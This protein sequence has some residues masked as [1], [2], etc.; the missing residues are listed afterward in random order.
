[1]CGLKL[2]GE[3]LYDNATVAFIDFVISIWWLF[4][5]TMLLKKERRGL[6][7]F[8]A[9]FGANV[10]SSLKSSNTVMEISLSIAITAAI[11]WFYNRNSVRDY[12]S[13]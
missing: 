4:A 2:F 13:T 9:S 7:M 6:S 12:L 3:P 8:N 5:I 11:F 1:M 10:L